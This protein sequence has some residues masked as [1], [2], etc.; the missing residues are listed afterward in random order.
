MMPSEMNSG[1]DLK[2]NWVVTSPHF[3]V[4]TEA[5]MMFQSHWRT[6]ALPTARRFPIDGSVNTGG[7]TPLHSTV[8]VS[9][10][11]WK[12]RQTYLHTGPRFTTQS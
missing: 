1:Y 8:Q 12:L 4:Q 10:D 6:T 11:V 3:V 2:L 5:A 7:K 9:K